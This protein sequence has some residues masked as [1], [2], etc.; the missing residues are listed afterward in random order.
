GA[1]TLGSVTGIIAAS[2]PGRVYTGLA[3]GSNS[4]GN[5]LYAADFA[6]GNIDVYNGTYALTTTTGGFVDPTIPTTVGNTYHPF[7][8]Q[9]IGGSLYVTYAKVDPITGEDVEGVGNG[10]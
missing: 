10:F 6:N 2:H 8:I 3:I 7:N 4:G 9:N 5:R 1:P